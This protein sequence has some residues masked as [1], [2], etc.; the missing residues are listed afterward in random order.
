MPTYQS[1]RQHAINFGEKKHWNLL[2]KYP[3]SSHI[4]VTD[5]D[6][7]G[8]LEWETCSRHWILSSVGGWKTIACCW[9]CKILILIIVI[10]LE[11]LTRL[12]PPTDIDIDDVLMS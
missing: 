11:V 3:K 6:G 10:L 8:E 1:P 12:S 9:S 7:E 5:S 2:R 4:V